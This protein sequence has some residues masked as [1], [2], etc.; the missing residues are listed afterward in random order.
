MEG[1]ASEILE[2]LGKQYLDHLIN[3]YDNK[4]ITKEKSLNKKEN[5][6]II[7]SFNKKK[8]FIEN[9]PCIEEGEEY[10]PE[11]IPSFT[12]LYA[13]ETGTAEGFANTLYKEANERLHLKAK[14][15]NVSEINSVKTFNE[16]SLIVIIASTWGEGGPTDDCVDFNKMLKRKKF[17]EEFTNEK[18]LNIAIF[19]LGNSNYTFYNA[20]G[21][22]FHKILVEEHKLNSICGLCLGD[23]K[24]DIERDFKNWTDNIFFKSLYSFYSKNYEQNYEFYKKFNLLN[25]LPK[26]NENEEI[27]K[28]YELFTSDKK[29][30][31]QIENKNYNQNVQNHL[32]A[33]KAKILNIEE[34]RQNNINGSTLKVVLELDKIDYKYKPA[35]NILIYPKNKEETINVVLNQLAMDK[36]TNYINYKLLNKNKD[37]SLNMPLPEE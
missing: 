11:L 14:I 23:S 35:E 20:Q 33:K 10:Y 37:I 29:E 16:N 21:K 1:K 15:F 12:I 4:K 3:N 25:D 32:N 28:N 18:N 26:E 24:Y 5:K 27:K 9:N 36:E 13:S 17:W 22:L 34:L 2:D 8:V 30:V 31:I 19:G 7:K 6:K